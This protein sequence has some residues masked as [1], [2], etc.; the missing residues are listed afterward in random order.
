MYCGGEHAR[1]ADVRRCWSERESGQDALFPITDRELGNDEVTQR[2]VPPAAAMPRASDPTAHARRGPGELTRTSWYCR[3]PSRPPEWAV[4]AGPCRRRRDRRPRR[5]RRR[6]APGGRTAA[7]RWSSSC[8]W[9]STNCPTRSIAPAT[10]A[11]RRAHVL[12]RRAAPTGLVQRRRRPN[13]VDGR[14]GRADRGRAGDGWPTNSQTASRRRRSCR[15]RSP[16]WLDG[17]PI[18]HLDPID[19]VAVVHVAADRA[20]ATADSASPNVTARRAGAR[21]AGG[22]RAR[23]RLGA[24]HRPGR[25]GQDAGAHRARPAPAQRVAPARRRR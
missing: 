23:R 11:R 4:P 14:R 8:A 21:P 13:V 20:P 24:H 3:E 10:P 2:D 18:R 7:S 16:V 9:R 22:G 1:P 25:V 15:R 6:S 19:G 12:A 17:G 5:D